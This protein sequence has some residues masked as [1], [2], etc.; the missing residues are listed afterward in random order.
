VSIRLLL[1]DDQAENRRLLRGVLEAEGMV[2]VGQAADGET[3]ARLAIELEPDVV[4]MDLW[5]PGIGGIEA[6][7]RI[8]SA[9]PGIQ[10]VILTDYDSPAAERSSV[11]AGA[12][13]YLVKGDSVELMFDVI[14]LAAQHEL[15]PRP[16]ECGGPPA[17]S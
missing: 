5:M 8:T 11:E 15:G 2:V 6:T 13:A 17:T 14:K 10:V 7:R 16:C 1:V 12:C 4:L 9:K 3:A